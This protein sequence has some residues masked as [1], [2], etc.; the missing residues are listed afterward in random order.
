ME[1]GGNHRAG[2]VVPK[3]CGEGVGVDE[4]EVA[5]SAAALLADLPTL[6]VAAQVFHFHAMACMNTNCQA[7]Y[8]VKKNPKTFTTL[9]CS[10]CLKRL[11]DCRTHY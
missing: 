3:L 2:P 10:S 9:L 5:A 1:G 11:P 8:A 4:E 6:L 7:G